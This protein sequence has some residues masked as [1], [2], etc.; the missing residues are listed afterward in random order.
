MTVRTATL[1]ALPFIL[2]A[3]GDAPPA[4]DPGATGARDAVTSTAPPERS[5]TIE[6]PAAGD[7]VPA[8]AVEVTLSVDGLTIVPA[9]DSTASS[10]HHHLFLDADVSPAGEPI[11]AVEGRIVHMGDGSL[12]YTFEN[13][14]PGAHRLIAVVGD[15]Q[16]VPLEPMVT[17]TIEFIAR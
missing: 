14:A 7:T 6:A 8:G 2:V 17:D 11:P 4:D 12:T 16:H 9:G 3:C 10:G 1:I 5:V 13:V 15:W